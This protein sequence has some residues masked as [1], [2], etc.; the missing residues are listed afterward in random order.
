MFC[1]ECMSL[2][3]RVCCFRLVKPDTRILKS[4]LFQMVLYGVKGAQLKL[5]HWIDYAVIFFVIVFALHYTYMYI[6]WYNGTHSHTL[7]DIDRENW[8]KTR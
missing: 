3:V 2:G 5:F 1:Q 4:F 7:L 8:S 6:N